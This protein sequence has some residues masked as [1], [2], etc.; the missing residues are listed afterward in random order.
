MIDILSSNEKSND[1]VYKVTK[2][3]VNL[4][5]QQTQENNSN[6]KARIS[7]EDDSNLTTSTNNA[8][9]LIDDCLVILLVIMNERNINQ[10][11][12]SDHSCMNTIV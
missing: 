7:K 9:H 2:A 1:T 5:F 12:V 4:S 6:M 3:K 10:T 11:V 8:Q